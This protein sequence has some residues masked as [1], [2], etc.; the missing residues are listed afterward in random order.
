[1]NDGWTV[2]GI[3]DLQ[4]LTFSGIDETLCKSINEEH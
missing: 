1:M 2:D 3:D 4:L